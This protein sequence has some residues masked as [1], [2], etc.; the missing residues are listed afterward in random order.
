MTLRTSGNPD[1]GSCV[2]SAKS[3]LVP[4]IQFNFDIRCRAFVMVSDGHRLAVCPSD[5]VSKTVCMEGI[6]VAL[7]VGFEQGLRGRVT[8]AG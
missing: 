3:Y 5:T 7:E 8:K 6:L 1:P 2:A 4:P